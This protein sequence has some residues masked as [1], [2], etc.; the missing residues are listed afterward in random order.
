MR[1]LKVAT[2]LDAAS[3]TVLEPVENV[4]VLRVS[5]MEEESVETMSP[6]ESSTATVR[7]GLKARP[8]GIVVGCCV[9]TSCAAGPKIV[10]LDEVAEVSEPSVAVSV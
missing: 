3:V 4:P 7:A 2:P 1:L 5:V 9:K 10:K 6:V 8:A